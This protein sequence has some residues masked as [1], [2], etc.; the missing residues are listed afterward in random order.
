LIGET[1]SHYKILEQIGEGGMGVVYK[2]LDTRLDRHVAIK[3]LPPQFRSDKDAKARFI[4]EAKAASALNHSN[5]AVVHDIGE[6]ADGQMFIV[7]A[8][9]DGQ[10]LRDKIK[11][12][13]VSVDETVDIVSQIASGLA[14]AHQ[15]DILHRDIKP[16][17][18][19]MTERGEA[20]LADFGLAKLAGQ[21][22]LTKTGTTVGTVSYMS[23]EQ[24]S[25]QEVDHR[26][27]VFSL[28]VVLYEL[29]T[30][31]VPFKGDHEAAVLYGIMHNEP[32][33]VASRRSDI[34]AGLQRVVD[35][36]LAKDPG[37]RYP[38]ASDLSMD[39]K[40]IHEG[41]R[42]VAPRRNLLRF[43][44]PSSVI[45]LA[46][47]LL[48][49]F[50]PFTLEMSP[51]QEAIAAENS[52]AI[53]YFEN[54]INRDDPQRLGE[55]VTN[56]LIT[57]LSESQY[58][59]VVSSQ[60]LYDILKLQGKQGEKVV[61]KNTAT[62]VATEAGSKWMLLGSILQEEPTIV[63]TS[64]LVEVESG[65]V[66][67]SQRI[68][69]EQG[70]EIFTLVDRLTGEIRSDLAL[71]VAAQAETDPSASDLTTSSTEAYRYYLEGEEYRSQL[72]FVNAF[73]SY[74]KAVAS[75]STFAIAYLRIWPTGPTFEAR[76][77]ALAKAVRYS[78]KASKKDQLYIRAADAAFQGNDDE[79]VRA[80]EKIIADYPGEKD[81]FRNLGSYYYRRNSKDKALEYYQEALA[82]DPLDKRTYNELAYLYDWQ[83]QFEKSIWAINK[84]IELAPDE[85]NPYDTRGDLYAFNGYLDEAIESYTMAQAI[86]P[87]FTTSVANL[88]HM[89]MFKLD[90]EHARVQ[91][92]KLV[93]GRDPE[94]RSAGRYYLANVAAYEGRLGL[95]LDQMDLAI[96]GDEMEGFNEFLYAVK[97]YSK[98]RI[99]SMLGEHDK[100]VAVGL[101]VMEIWESLY[102]G[103]PD[104]DALT[105]TLKALMFAQN[106]RVSLAA[107]MAAAA[108]SIVT[109]SSSPLLRQTLFLAKAVIALESGNA[110]A[111]CDYLEK[112]AEM[113]P[114]FHVGYH[115]GIAYLRS[116]RLPESIEQFGKILK[117]YDSTRAGAPMENVMARFYLG[118]AYEK[119]EQHK[120]AADQYKEFLDLWKDA[121]RGIEEV[122]DAKRRL[123]ALRGS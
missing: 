77:E 64:Q 98:A 25:G 54:L 9:Y 70:E 57:D 109:E 48:L 49:I 22:K 84:Y 91:Y 113:R 40:R 61:D 115:L 41:L 39:L 3:F 86:N 58:L 45:V 93:A 19:L 72:L 67:A 46:A 116:N 37:D 31:E 78:Y 1:V 30:G 62:R 7:M 73:E 74:R 35:R 52:V 27:D 104:G 44:I 56:L 66:T 5:I 119:S 90:Y 120:K 14:A 107:E 87:D 112:A 18:I 65:D 103:M 11:G 80:Y 12:G 47:I 28:G 24:A 4:H 117:R 43:A 123:A 20:K 76:K 118:E 23:P 97:V 33:P 79:Q 82:L 69:G 71:P 81:A 6:T 95:A 42:P 29:L 26:S 17:N 89:Y 88:G 92:R 32:E 55:I 10:T 2:A 34:P 106:K 122:E 83:G 50:K 85:P 8:Y 13:P 75:D 36:M 105:S 59:T 60:R 101:R 51:D 110:T 114:N 96:A 68:L 99:Y 100:S 111:A 21:T 102:D 63:I 108:D 53:M 121:D 16:A 38:S 94:T 15:K